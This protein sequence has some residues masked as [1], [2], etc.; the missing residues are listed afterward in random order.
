MYVRSCHFSKDISINHIC[1]CHSSLVDLILLPDGY[2]LRQLLDY[3][4]IYLSLTH[5][6]KQRRHVSSRF[7]SNFEVNY[8]KILKNL[9]SVQITGVLPVAKGL[10]TSIAVKY[11]S[12]ANSEKAKST[13]ETQII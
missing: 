2:L 1:I 11:M 13:I 9:S 8:K 10:T 5:H 7:Y 3:K 12:L 6:Y 4:V